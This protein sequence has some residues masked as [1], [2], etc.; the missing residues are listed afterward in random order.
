MDSAQERGRRLPHRARLEAQKRFEAGREIEVFAPQGPIPDAVVAGEDGVFEA[1]FAS[2]ELAF[3]VLVVANKAAGNDDCEQHQRDTRGDIDQHQQ[4]AGLPR[5]F[6]Q[7]RSHRVAHGSQLALQCPHTGH[8]LLQV[9]GLRFSTCDD[10]AQ[11][12]T[13]GGELGD[14]RVCH[15]PEGGGG[16]HEPDAPEAPIPIDDALDILGMDTGFA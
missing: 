14:L 6:A 3:D 1:L 16:R 4:V 15:V 13:R 10:R 12:L 8:G 11:G 9:G 5:R 2:P 7:C